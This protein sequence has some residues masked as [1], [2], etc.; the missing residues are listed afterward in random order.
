MA[1]TELTAADPWGLGARV[2][3]LGD[4]WP[5]LSGAAI[6]AV[7]ALTGSV[8]AFGLTLGVLAA[9]QRRGVVTAATYDGTADDAA[10]TFLDEL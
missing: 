4:L 2:D 10:L 8:E 9:A 6:L 7:A 1:V 5:W 3:R